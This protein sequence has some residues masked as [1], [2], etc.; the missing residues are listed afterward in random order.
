M[1]ACLTPPITGVN[2]ESA[3]VPVAHADTSNLDG[4]TDL[5]IFLL[6]GQSNMVGAPRP[7]AADE[8]ENPR[9]KVLAYE[10]CSGLGRT[11]NEWYTAKPPLHGCYGGLGPGDYFAKTIATAYPNATIGL[12]PLAINGVDI[13]FF[14]KGVV[15]KRRREFSI[16][17]DNHWTGAYDWGLE[18]ARLAQKV[19]H[20]HGII[21]HQGESDSG[22]PEWVGKVKQ[23]VTDL[24]SDLGLGE[25]PFV[26]GELLYTGCCGKWHN[27]LM[28]QL[29]REISNTRVVSANG[30]SGQDAA[31]FDLAGQRELGKRYAAAMLELMKTRSQ[32]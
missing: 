18:R 31:H 21:F 9:V 11:Y 29:T 4:K 28:P 19:G 26:A 24:R 30:L 14:E 25:V 27:S 7:E 16:P 1:A 13:D 22:S 15:S 12:V 10:T 8:V 32:P 6:I 5:M 3:S 20:I 23:M 17:P 2:N